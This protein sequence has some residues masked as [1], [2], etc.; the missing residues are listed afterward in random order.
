MDLTLKIWR[1]A[2]V[3][4]DGKITA[5]DSPWD[6]FPDTTANVLGQK[7]GYLPGKLTT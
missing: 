6:C 3:D 5:L 2:S 7:S 4:E 1:Q